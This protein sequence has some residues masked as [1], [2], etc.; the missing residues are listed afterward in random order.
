MNYI[1]FYSI[2]F[3]SLRY[4]RYDVGGRDRWQAVNKTDGIWLGLHEQQRYTCRAITCY[5]E[6][7]R[8]EK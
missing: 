5:G 6:L 2:F 8:E 4:E 1:L 3:F 7:D